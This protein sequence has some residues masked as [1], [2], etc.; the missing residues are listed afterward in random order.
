MKIKTLLILVFVVLLATTSAF[1]QKGRGTPFSGTEYFDPFG[2]LGG[3]QIGTILPSDSTIACPGHEPTGNPVQPCPAGSRT[4]MRNFRIMS[5][6]V[7]STPALSSGWMTIVMNANLDAEF[8]G[9]QW[10]T[11]S[12]A[13]DTGG[14]L[15]GT[16]EGLRVMEGDHWITPLHANGFGNG[17][18]AGAH[19]LISD[20]IV[21][22]T[23]IPIAYIGTVEGRLLLPN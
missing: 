6:Y 5:R 17:S 9:P 7:S 11:F 15:D 10:G 22:Y 19:V 18:M 16:W 12:L 20:R 1:A 14:T 13:L 2:L 4:H 23:P 8:T 3:G 21:G